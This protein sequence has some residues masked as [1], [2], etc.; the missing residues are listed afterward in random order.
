[1]AP[2]TTIAEIGKAR[3]RQVIAR[4]TPRSGIWER[5]APA[6]PVAEATNPAQTRSERTS[7]AHVAFVVLKLRT[8]E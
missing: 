4:L 1:M 2:V 7:Q 5:E 3:I 8:D 6:E